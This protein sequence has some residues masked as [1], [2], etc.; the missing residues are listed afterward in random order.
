MRPPGGLLP[1]GARRNAAEGGQG[2]I[3]SASFFVTF[4]TLWPAVL[5]ADSSAFL[6]P[7]AAFRVPAAI[8]CLAFFLGFLVAFSR[9]FAV[10]A[11]LR[12]TALAA[13]FTVLTASFLVTIRSL[14]F[15]A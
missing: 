7:T 9:S 3:L 12:D 10:L 2:S 4:S 13:F 14:L 11:A 1:P 6:A 8:A 5:P 15:V